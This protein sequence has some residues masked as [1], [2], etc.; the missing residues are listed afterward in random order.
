MKVYPKL[1]TAAER[2]SFTKGQSPFVIDPRTNCWMPIWDMVM[3]FALGFTA[4]WTPYEVTF[5][6]EANVLRDGPD[7]LW[8]LNRVMDLLFIM[9]ILLICN[10]MY[11]Q[12]LEMGGMWVGSRRTIILNYM[13][14]PWFWIDIIAVFPFYVVGWMIAGSSI[15][16]PDTPDGS[17]TNS[18]AT[19]RLVRFG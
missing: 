16:E 4:S 10:T 12:P 6:T 18:L 14:T 8:I 5:L 15:Y 1:L 17:S 9:D 19:V 3:L 7:A 2:A 11:E 13:K